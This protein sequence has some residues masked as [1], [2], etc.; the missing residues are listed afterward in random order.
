MKKLWINEREFVLFKEAKTSLSKELATRKRSIDYYSII[1]NLPDPD[2]V[3]KEQGKDISVYRELLTDP[4][5]WACIQSRKSGI[6]SLEWEIDRGMPKSKQAE[7]IEGLFNDIDLHNLISEILD[8]TLFGF[9]PIEINWKRQGS[10]LLPYEIKAKPPEWFV[11]DDDNRLKLRTKDN[12]YGEELEEHK[13]LCPQY[14]PTYINPYGERILS[15]V[16]WSVMFKSTGMEFWATF[17]E[18][19][20]MPFIL[21]KH[22]R[23]TY[24]GDS[25]NLMYMLENLVQ[26]AVAVIP[27]DSD[28]QLFEANKTS[29]ADIY[30]RLIDKM[31]A[32]I[33][34]AVL[35]QTLTTEIGDK[36]SYAASNTHMDVRHDIIEA[37]KRLVEKTLNQLIHWIYQENFGAL[38]QKNIPEFSLFEEEETDLNLVSQR[39]KAVTELS[40]IKFTKTYLMKTYGY[41]ED[42]FEM[43]EAGVQTHSDKMPGESEPENKE[44]NK[45]PE[46]EF[47]EF[48][49]SQFPDQQAIDKFIDSFSDDELQTQADTILKPIFQLINNADSYEEIYEKLSE[50]GLKTDEIEK[51]LQKVI[52]T[53]QTWGQINGLE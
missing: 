39:D 40:G 50:K 19:Y 22:P 31:N 12:Y 4:H 45:E 30:E 14:N 18:K 51:I 1:K 3:L 6:L 34:K 48:A 46:S 27:H 35:G 42:D 25:D 5:V 36:G 49:E 53:S 41:E 26:D 43:P 20:G 17:T 16:F 33:S 7:I 13:F 29:S 8:A 9:Q 24:D 47:K 37:D 32:E 15:R 23:A 21:G 2:P 10:L 28:V 38:K 44:E 52:F 11:F